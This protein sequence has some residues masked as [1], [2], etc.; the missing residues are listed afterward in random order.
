MRK[1]TAVWSV[2]CEMGSVHSMTVQWVVCTVRLFRGQCT[3]VWLCSETVATF[4]KDELCQFL[5]GGPAFA[6]HVDYAH[7]RGGQV[8]QHPPVTRERRNNHLHSW[9][10]WATTEGAKGEISLDSRICEP[11]SKVTSFLLNILLGFECSKLDQI[12]HHII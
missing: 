4:I 7:V 5:L 6:A 3:Q 9:D 8:D 10:L 2:K 1:Q 12:W 11:W